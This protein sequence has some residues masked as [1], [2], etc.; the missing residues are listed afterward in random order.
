VRFLK[1]I[2]MAVVLVLLG[3]SVASGQIG[4]TPEI[5]ETLKWHPL[6]GS[7]VVYEIHGADVGNETMEV[8]V[9]SK[10]R[11][12]GKD[13]FWIEATGKR[14][15]RAEWIMKL[16]VAGDAPHTQTLRWIFQVAGHP[17]MEMPVKMQSGQEHDSPGAD[18][19][20]REIVAVPAG[21]YACT[22][23]RLKDGSGETWVSEKVVLWGLVK[24]QHTSRGRARSMVLLRTITGA[25]D[26]I[27]EA[28]QPFDP[29]I[30]QQ[31]PLSQP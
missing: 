17:P 19:L 22:H 8:N 14:P 31:A 23:Y 11:V 2:S 27:T 29:K 6:V 4:L 3:A 16:L 28:P 5:Q 15:G 13:A 21:T 9:L 10:E 18:D 12:K 24:E 1:Y 26:K 30:M 20:G 25:K 7:G